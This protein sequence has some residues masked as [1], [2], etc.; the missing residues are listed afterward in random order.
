M[1]IISNF[2]VF[3]RITSNMAREFDR[4]K[5]GTEES[6]SFV[7]FPIESNLLKVNRKRGVNNGRRAMEA[8]NNR[9]FQNRGV[10]EWLG[11]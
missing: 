9:P 3:E 7:L 4:I 2:S 1:K 8:I 6:Y 11:V 5:K 10:F